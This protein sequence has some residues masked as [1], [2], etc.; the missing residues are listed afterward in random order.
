MDRDLDYARIGG[1]GGRSR[2]GGRGGL[3]AVGTYGNLGHQDG[4]GLA[5]D[6]K[7]LNEKLLL[8]NELLARD[9]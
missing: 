4:L 5:V 6:Q 1:L 8:K 3:G 7:L 2:I 9:R